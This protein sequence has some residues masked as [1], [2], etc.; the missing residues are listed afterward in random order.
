MRAGT[1]VRARWMADKSAPHGCTIQHKGAWFRGRVERVHPGGACDVRYDD[2]DFEPNVLPV[3]VRPTSNEGDDPD[4]EEEEEAVAA[5]DPAWQRSGHDLLGRRIRRH[6]DGH[7]WVG[8]V[9][10]MWRPGPPETL[11][12]AAHDDGD[13]EDLSEEQARQAVRDADD[14][15]GAAPAPAAAPSKKAAGKKA[16]PRRRRWWRRRGQA[17]PE[18]E[19]APATSASTTS[20]ASSR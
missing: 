18:P 12:K 7:G 2:G 11:F 13:K 14:E 17:A 5:A 20:R 19:P 10:V 15:A 8:G 3:N 6:F 1:R 4:D 9:L 16:A